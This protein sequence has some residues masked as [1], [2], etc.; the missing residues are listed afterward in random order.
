[1]RKERRQKGRSRRN[2]GKKKQIREGRKV[3][4]RKK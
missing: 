2:V 3:R 4:N 1:M